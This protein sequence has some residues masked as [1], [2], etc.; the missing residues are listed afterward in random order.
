M[1]NSGIDLAV[2]VMGYL[3]GIAVPVVSQKWGVIVNP[4]FRTQRNSD[5]VAVKLR[6]LKK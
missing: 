4:P 5:D 3:A 1:Y 2:V 6:K